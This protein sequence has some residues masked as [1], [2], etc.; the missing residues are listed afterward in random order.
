MSKKATEDS[1]AT[2]HMTL[3]EVLTTKINAA[4]EEGDSKG[5]AALLNVARQFLKDN[6]IEADLNPGTPMSNLVESL[7]FPNLDDDERGLRP[8]N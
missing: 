7:P 3:A 8:L 1:L 2:L 4:S 5:L 6:G